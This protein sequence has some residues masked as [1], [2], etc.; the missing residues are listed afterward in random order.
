MLDL[1]GKKLVTNQYIM[2]ANLTSRKFVS[3][4]LCHFFAI[5]VGDKYYLLYFTKAEY[6]LKHCNKVE[7]SLKQLMFI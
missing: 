7:I 6:T 4:F 3:F 2:Q 1:I 5:Q